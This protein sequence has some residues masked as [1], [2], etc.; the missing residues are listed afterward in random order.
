MNVIMQRFFT[1]RDD[2]LLMISAY[3]LLA[4]IGAVVLA[5]T[6][7]ATDRWV[8]IALLLTFGV[9]MA[10]MPDTGTSA[11]RVHIYLGVQTVIILST[12]FLLSASG[13]V[14]LFF[15]LSVQAML[16]LPGR[17]GFL[18]I[19]IFTLITGGTYFY[20]SDAPGDALVQTLVNG[21]GYLF[22]GAFGNA[23][24]RAENA[25][26]ESERLLSELRDAHRQL[27]AYAQRVEELAIAEERNR[28]AREM[29]D[30]LGHR[31]T[32]ASVQLEG[33]QRL[34]PDD[35]DRASQM[36]TTVREQVREALQ[37]LRSTVATL[38]TPL[39]ADL[40]LPK[41]LERLA[42]E[43]DQATDLIVHLDLTDE[44]FEIPGSQHH[45]LYRAAQEGLTNVQRHAQAKEVWLDLHRQNG[46]IT[47]TVADDGIGVADEQDVDAGFGLHGLRERAMQLG[48]D[49]SLEPR[50]GGG[51]QLVFQIPVEHTDG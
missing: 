17:L 4:V 14:L 25:R 23:L 50:P 45:A 48:G 21:A 19:G 46:M 9:A 43:F 33:A 10:R 3:I 34:I 47:L 38:R 13:F 30:T 6:Q 18:W 42:Q 22:F 29:H 20:Y 49:L 37:E 5:S 8:A 27:Q 31:L 16:L 1:R 40:S 41:A 36:V 26:K 12:T 51:T 39:Q 15:I 2:V 32:V 44:A 35:P 7:D 24:V 11:Q 28:L